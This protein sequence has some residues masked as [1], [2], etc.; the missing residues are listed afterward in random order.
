V[1]R[2][3]LPRKKKQSSLSKEPGVL[4]NNGA[5]SIVNF[6]ESDTKERQRNVG[7]DEPFTRF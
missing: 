4:I 1:R 2:T 7:M 3:K 6:V 5:K